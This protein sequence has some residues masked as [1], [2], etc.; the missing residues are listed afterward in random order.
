MAANSS[1]NVNITKGPLIALA[2]NFSGNHF[3]AVEKCFSE[4]AGLVDLTDM[5]DLEDLAYYLEDESCFKGELPV[6]NNIR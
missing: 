6:V 2:G 5:T 1:I 3:Q 4:G